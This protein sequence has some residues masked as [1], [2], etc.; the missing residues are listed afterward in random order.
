MRF[1]TLSSPSHSRVRS[2]TRLARRRRFAIWARCAGSNATT[3]RQQALTL[4]RRIGHQ[5]SQAQALNGMGNLMLATGQLGQSR[6]QHGLALD[7][8]T[9]IG[10]KY[11]QG[12][13]HDGLAHAHKAGRDLSRA[14]HHWQ[15]A[16]ALYTDLDVPEASEVLR[17]LVLL[18]KFEHGYPAL[19]S[20]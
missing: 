16:L 4:F 1:I 13:A 5:A 9:R 6:A 10:D 15:Q 8:A 19:A 14:Y 18:G 12:A 11:Q 3:S 2:A 20:R 7:L 17:H